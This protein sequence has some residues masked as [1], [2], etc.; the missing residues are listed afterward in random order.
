MDYRN[1]KKSFVLMEEQSRNFAL[2]K[3][4]KIRGYLKLQIG[5]GRGS[6]RVGVENLRCFERGSYVYKLIF[7]GKKNEKTLYK[8]AGDLMISGRGRGETYLRLDPADVDGKGNGLEWFT[9]AIVVAVSATDNRE[10]LHP[11]LRGSLEAPVKASSKRDRKSYNSYYNQY[12]LQCCKAIEDKKEIYDSL[13]PF[14][15]DRTGAQWRRIVNLGKFPLVSPGAQYP[16]S[17]YRHFIF[18]LSPD[19]YFVGVPGR[20]LEKEQPDGG[21]SGFVLWQPIMGAEGYHADSEDASLE[22]RQVAY[23]YWIAAIN[24]NTGSIESFAK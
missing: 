2:D 5:E 1:H 17:R 12:V 16:M 14:K 7:F 13:I 20:C 23:G 21:R 3:R 8:I 22:S 15:E 10:P 11:I 18:G 24:R 6:V 19:Y 4:E 9:I